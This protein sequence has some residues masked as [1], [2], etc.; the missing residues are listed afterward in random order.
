MYKVIRWTVADA[1]QFC[2]IY[3][4]ADTCKQSRRLVPDIVPKSVPISVLLLL[5]SLNVRTNTCN[6]IVF[7]Q[8]ITYMFNLEK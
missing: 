7:P 2:L 3:G 4:G 1:Q 8:Y 5:I 6:P